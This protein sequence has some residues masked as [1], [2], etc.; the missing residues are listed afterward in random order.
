MSHIVTFCDK[1]ITEKTVKLIKQ[2]LKQLVTQNKGWKSRIRRNPKTIASNEAVTKKILHNPKFKKYNNLKYKPKA[3][4]ETT[5]LTDENGN[6]KKT[7]YAK[8]LRANIKPTRGISKTDNTGYNNKPDIQE[9]S[10]TKPNQQI[11]KTREYSFKK[12][13]KLKHQK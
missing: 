2:S 4:V 10:F 5:N 13:I 3:A 12:I 6:L 8:I 9:T 11:Q 7:T 1:T